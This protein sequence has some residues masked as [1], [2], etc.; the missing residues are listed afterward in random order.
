MCAF[1]GFFLSCVRLQLLIYSVG[2]MRKHSKKYI[3]GILSILIL[4]CAI[5]A[6]EQE[7]VVLYY[8]ERTI[9]TPIN[10]KGEFKHL[11]TGNSNILSF[12]GTVENLNGKYLTHI[13]LSITKTGT[14]LGK[15]INTKLLL[16]KNE[17]IKVDKL[18]YL[19][20]K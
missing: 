2:N 16:T 6:K 10:K 3:I 1:R 7:E 15:K 12:S 17:R 20:I 13:N 8:G 11:E 19:K 14:E 9:S 4:G 18:T 5:T